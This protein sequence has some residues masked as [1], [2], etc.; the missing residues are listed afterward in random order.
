MGLTAS[1]KIGSSTKSDHPQEGRKL[2]ELQPESWV[3]DTSKKEMIYNKYQDEQIVE[4]VPAPR[5]DY[6]LVRLKNGHEYYVRVVY[7]WRVWRTENR[8]PVD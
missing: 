2:E 1:Y 5:E 6:C 4:I 8:S 7:G 3:L